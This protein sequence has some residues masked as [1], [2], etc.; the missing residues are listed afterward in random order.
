MAAITLAVILHAVAI[1]VVAIP[2]SFALVPGAVNS[3][4]FIDYAKE[5]SRKT[6][7]LNN[8]TKKLKHNPT[9][10]DLKQLLEEIEQQSNK[11]SLGKLVKVASNINVVNKPTIHDLLANFGQFTLNQVHGHAA[12]FDTILTREAH[13]AMQLTLCIL[14]FF[15]SIDLESEMYKINKTKVGFLVIS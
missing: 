5:D 2:T 8:V 7:N 12:I 14:K 11:A 10:V 13:V 6:F 4:V 15:T 9:G 1:H 3:N